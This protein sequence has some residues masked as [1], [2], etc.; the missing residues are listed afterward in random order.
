MF[1][2]YPSAS[3]GYNQFFDKT[4]KGCKFVPECNVG[5]FDPETRK[6]K[7]SKGEFTGDI[8]INTLSVDKLFK[9]KFGV[10]KYSG[11]KMFKVVLP[12]S[13]IIPDDVTWIHYTGDEPFTRITEFKKITGHKS[14][15]TL[16][17]IEIPSP[18]GQH[19]PV[20]TEEEK[21]K[22]SQ[23]QKLFPENFYSIGRMGSFSYKGIPEV[24]RDALDTLKAILS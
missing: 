7:T 9:N 3:D 19:Y 12:A 8:I 14:K 11:R 4:L 13:Q 15:N 16:L 1:Q 22:F 6:I 23:Y 24:M 21:L 5:S 18:G 2:G 17:G 20:Q 10:L